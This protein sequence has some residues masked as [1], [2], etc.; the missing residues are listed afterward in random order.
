MKKRYR[1]FC[2]PFIAIGLV[3]LF[4]L[5]N[6]LTLVAQA[7]GNDSVIPGS[8]TAP[9]GGGPIV[10]IDNTQT[11]DEPQQPPA[12]PVNPTPDIT[13]AGESGNTTVVGGID[14][15]SGIA[16]PPTEPIP[17]NPDG[18]TIDGVFPG[19]GI[20]GDEV[21]LPPEPTPDP[22]GKTPGRLD[23]SGITVV[24]PSIAELTV[25]GADLEALL[26]PSGLKLPTK[27]MD[28]LMFAPVNYSATLVD[29]TAYF[30]KTIAPTEDSVYTY[31]EYSAA[32]T[33]LTI[34]RIMCIVGDSDN[35]SATSEAFISL[36]NNTTVNWMHNVTN[37]TLS[38]STRVVTL[39]DNYK[40]LLE[41]AAG[42]NEINKHRQYKDL[43]AD[44][45]GVQYS[46]G[47]LS[48]LR[49]AVGAAPS[50][51]AA[52]SK[53]VLSLYSWWDYAGVMQNL[54]SAITEYSHYYNDFAYNGINFTK[55]APLG[56][57]HSDQGTQSGNST[58]VNPGA[59][60]P[61]N[62]GGDS[63]FSGNTTQVGGIGTTTPEGGNIVTGGSTQEDWVTAVP[64]GSGDTPVSS[65]GSK[66]V[67]DTSGLP[68]G[69]LGLKEAGSIA[70][71]VFI[72][73]AVI[74]LLIIRISRR[75]GRLF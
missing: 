36:D 39:I 12:V 18:T 14:G 44:H 17:I 4:C 21:T 28:L 48:V 57:L 52:L 9:P 71:L 27:Y 30:L 50:N 61:A 8:E 2:P 56:I 15:T 19:D 65:V 69:A 58:Q 5:I 68:A 29:E 66:G 6:S 47:D 38:D 74:G 25:K 37:A 63:G 11:G 22:V 67:H 35:P 33:Y 10:I 1:G 41:S 46:C 34:C 13:T 62:P 55:G 20:P 59:T 3:I 64:G 7:M 75:G 32:D 53:H 42:G 31:A 54:T 49:D 60:D 73:V 24:S 23:T 40:D 43:V 72:G 70:A 26:Y 16:T 51:D 45:R